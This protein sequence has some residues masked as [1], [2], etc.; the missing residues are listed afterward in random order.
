MSQGRLISLIVLYLVLLGALWGYIGASGLEPR[1]GLDLQGG[2]SANLIP[3]E[4]QEDVDI[5]VLDQTVEII[6]DRVDA[7][8]VAEPEVARQGETIQVQLP[9]VADQEQAREVIGRT[10]QLQFRQV[11][12]QLPPGVDPETLDETVDTGASELPAVDPTPSEQSDAPTEEATTEGATTEGATTEG[13]TTEEG[14]TPAPAD[15]CDED[16]AAALIDP[17]EPATLPLETRD[18]NG[19]LLP[20]DQWPQLQLEPAEVSGNDLTDAVAEIPP[21]ALLETWQTRLEFDGEGAAAFEAVTAELACNQ[22]VTRQLA[23]V[24]D[25][26]VVDAPPVAPEVACGEGIGGGTAVIQ[27]ANE[28]EARE[29]ALVLRA[30][31][32][33]IQ[34]DFGTFQTISATLGQD[35][36]DA[37]IL[38]GLIGLVLVAVYLTVLYRGMGVAAVVEL[39]LFGATVF[40]LIIALGQW[41]GFTLTLSGIA[42]VIV[43]IGIAADSSIIYRERYRDEVRAGRTVRTAADHAFSKA[44]RTNLTGNTVSF[45]AAAVLYFLAVGQVR[46]FAFTLGLSTLIDTALF[47]TFTRGLFGLI[48]QSPSLANSKLIGL[49]AGVTSEQLEAAAANRRAG[50]KNA[51]KKRK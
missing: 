35:S 19:D 12:A 4:C 29:R 36:L 6:R 7:L 8:G 9:G 16:S 31:A 11:V 20:R 40:G 21:G 10:A 37:G 3:N 15:G 45:L 18:A 39:L 25:D 14:V 30:G 44:F 41:I 43:S 28:D 49:R 22:G 26:A 27:A 32:L 13:A 5:D 42:G 17:D 46:G 47:A 24:L 50:R 2:V 48:A 23:I 38:A 51:R 33:P 1:L 34:L